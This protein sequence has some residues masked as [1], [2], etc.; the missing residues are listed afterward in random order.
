[1]KKIIRL[2]E[3]DLRRIV[4]RVIKESESSVEAS[5][6]AFNMNY[7]SKTFTFYDPKCDMKIMEVKLTKEGCKSPTKDYLGCNSIF[8]VVEVMDYTEY[9]EDGPDNGCNRKLHRFL[10]GDREGR[11]STLPS[12]KDPFLDSVELEVYFDCEE[13][14]LYLK[15]KK[16]M[17]GGD[18]MFKIECPELEEICVDYCDASD[19]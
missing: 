12:S 18:Q 7:S 16:K 10:T 17:F 11:D 14:Q 9:F 8:E 3:N 6:K 5:N 15:G 1:M 2:T 4:N 13:Q 19:N